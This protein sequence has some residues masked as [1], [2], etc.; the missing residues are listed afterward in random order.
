MEIYTRWNIKTPIE[1]EI[2]PWEI[3]E[4][5]QCEGLKQENK[6]WILILFQTRIEIKA[7]K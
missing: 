2:L 5:Y 3:N 7:K 1:D 6:L 4:N